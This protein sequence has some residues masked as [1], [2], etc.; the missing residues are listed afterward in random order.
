MSSVSNCE[1]SVV[2]KQI[3]FILKRLEISQN[4][5]KLDSFLAEDVDR[6]YIH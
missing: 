5:R 1:V 3:I 6:V 4:F 2:A